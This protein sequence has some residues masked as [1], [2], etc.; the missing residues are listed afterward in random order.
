MQL[1]MSTKGQKRTSSIAPPS[2]IDEF[3]RPRK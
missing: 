2:A 3:F 1:E